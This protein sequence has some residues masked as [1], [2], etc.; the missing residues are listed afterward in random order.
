MLAVARALLTNP[1]L[2]ILDEPSEGLAP[3]V[4]AQLAAMLGE[5]V[6]DG[7]A[8]LIAE[9][10]LALA[11]AIA[12]RL[13]VIDRGRIAITCP[14]RQ[15]DEPTQRH[16]LHRLLGVTVSANLDSKGSAS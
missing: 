10:N 1:R 16:R 11:T 2:L 14:A 3:A 8:V 13:E 7:L 12:D 5:L 9:Q 15:L 6:A 4:T